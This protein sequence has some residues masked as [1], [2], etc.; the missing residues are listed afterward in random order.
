MA[1]CC[2]WCGEVFWTAISDW[3][4]LASSDSAVCL[5][6]QRSISRSIPMAGCNPRESRAKFRTLTTNLLPSHV[7]N[8]VGCI[9]LAIGS[10]RSN[11]HGTRLIVGKV[12][13]FGV[14][15]IEQIGVRLEVGATPGRL[16]HSL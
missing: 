13:V 7:G 6:S 15:W 10:S 4:R 12:L 16:V 5:Q 1:E 14:P 8:I 3:T 11:G 2:M 9:E